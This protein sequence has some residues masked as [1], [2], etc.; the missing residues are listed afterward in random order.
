MYAT[1]RMNPS[2]LPILK[3][4]RENINRTIVKIIIRMTSIK[5]LSFTA[6]GEMVAEA[7][8]TN[9]ILKILLPT[10]LP[11][12]ISLSFLTLQ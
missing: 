8:S 4:V 6:N 3:L 2:L 11:K 10:I 1:A 5:T 9:K 7:P 12:A